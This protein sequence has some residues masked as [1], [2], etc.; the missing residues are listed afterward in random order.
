MSEKTDRASKT[1]SASYHL[2]DT[3]LARAVAWAEAAV[4]ILFALSLGIGSWEQSQVDLFNAIFVAALAGIFLIGIV[5]RFLGNI[6]LERRTLS[7]VTMILAGCLMVSYSALV[8]GAAGSTLLIFL[9]LAMPGTMLSVVGVGLLVVKEKPSGRMAGYYMLWLFGI[10]LV[11]FMPLH[12]LGILDYSNRDILVGLFGLGISLIGS[13]SFIAELR[14]SG[15]VEAW[16]TAGD[17]KYI[18]GKFDEAVE[19]YEQALYS[20]PRNAK[21]WAN[22]GSAHLRLGSWAKAV[23]CFDRALDIDSSLA[24]A[25]SGRGLA[26]THLKRFSEALESHDRAIAIDNSPVSWNNRG[27][28]LVRMGAP[29]RNAIECYRKALAIDPEYEIAWFNRGKAELMDDGVKDAIASLTRAVELNPQFADAWFQ[30][31]KALSMA[32]GRDDEALYCFD[33]AI[34]L[35]PTN[36]EAWMERKILL[37]SMKE[38]RVRPIALVNLPQT[39]VV[40]GPAARGQPLLETTGVRAEDARLAAGSAKLRDGALRMATMGDYGTA[41]SALDERLS[42]VPDDVV[43][44]MTKGVLLSRIEKFDEALASF[45]AAMALKPDWVGPMFSKGMI[46]AAKGE[47]A[48]AIAIMERVTDKRPA[49]ADAWSVKGIILG[50]Q[51]KYREAIACFDRV[52]ELNPNSEDAWRSKSTALNKL[53]R[54]EEAI[55]CYEKLAA[56]SPAIE[57]T[58][59]FLQE[60]KGKLEDARTL[61]RQGVDLAKSRLYP[62]GLALLR[63]ATELRPNYIDALYISGVING[64][65]GNYADAMQHFERVLELRPSHVES[66]YGKANI[67]LKKGSYAM[68]LELLDNVL[69]LDWDHVDAWCDRGVALVKLGKQSDALECYDHALKIAGDHPQAIAQRERCVRAMKDAIGEQT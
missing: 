30:K 27:N 49:Y 34:E 22:S 58:R 31:G 13:A 52:I 35:K 63:Q 4:A 61:F 26:L 10:L 9:I 57:E 12:E 66:M 1:T 55:F 5:L 51:K 53:G 23:A 25:H 62:E 17:A 40:F 39:G 60:E 45:D 33:T 43:T 36:A 3:S 69:A 16:V 38:T 68:A 64:V 41:L 32:G 46:L 14:L 24:I 48:A 7:L 29:L 8:Y 18:A 20:E 15:R 54:Y 42:K 11:L 65:M 59:R 44:H 37:T 50:T 6:A 28:T 19:Y 2:K 56:L 21:V 47:Y 67:L